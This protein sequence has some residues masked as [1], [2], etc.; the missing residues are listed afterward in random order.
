MVSYRVPNDFECQVGLE[1]SILL[2][3]ESGFADEWLRLNTQRL[4][5]LGTLELDEESIS[6]AHVLVQ[7]EPLHRAYRARISGRE[8]VETGLDLDHEQD[9]PGY[10]LRA[11]ADYATV[12]LDSDGRRDLILLRDVEVS[13]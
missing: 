11:I 2:S 10:E 7:T 3:T 6:E 8:L 12:D 1:T 13:R 9:F 5:V 4:R